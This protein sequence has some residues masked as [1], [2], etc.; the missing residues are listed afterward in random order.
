MVNDQDKEQGGELR[1]RGDDGGERWCREGG[2]R[3]KG[4]A[5]V[6]WREKEK[7]EARGTMTSSPDHY[8][9]R[10]SAGQSLGQ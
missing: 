7:G 6:Q 10:P 8:V 5:G 1:R 4:K 9:H 3:T 2:G